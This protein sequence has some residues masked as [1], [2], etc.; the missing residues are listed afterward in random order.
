MNTNYTLLVSYI[1]Y[2]GLSQKITLFITPKSQTFEYS[3]NYFNFFLRK[4]CLLEQ[5]VIFDILICLTPH[6]AFRLDDIQC[7]GW[8][9]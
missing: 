9:V 6:F 2:V 8:F 1:K 3:C 7:L 5:F 4:H